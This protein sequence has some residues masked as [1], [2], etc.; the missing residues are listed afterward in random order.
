MSLRSKIILVLAV[1]AVAWAVGD[2]LLLETMVT[3][4]F[5]AMG[6]EEV[7]QGLELV[8]SCID[9]EVELL[10]EKARFVAS[11]ETTRRFVTESDA[12]LV[13]SYLG[14]RSL[15]VVGAH[16]M[17]VCDRDGNVR[18][19]RIE[20]PE[21]RE[22][23]S[24]KTSFPSESL[25]PTHP[26]LARDKEVELSYLTTER[27]IMLVTAEPVTRP[28]EETRSGTV[29]MGRFLDEELKAGI[30]ARTS[31]PFEIWDIHDASLDERERKLVDRFTSDTGE[32]LIDED[33]DKNLFAYKTLEGVAGRPD[34][35]LR[36]K[37]EH[38]ILAQGAKI[39]D[40]LLLST[41]GTSILIFLV[42]LRVL[43]RTVINPLTRFTRF[44]I[45]VAE[46]DD[47]SA[48]MQ[49]DRPDEV[50]ILSREF[51]RMLEEIE[52]SRSLLVQTARQAG[53]SEIATGVLHNVGNVL[54]SV[55]VSATL[56]NRQVG[57]LAVSDLSKF[58][59]VL[60]ENEENLA[61]FIA[62]DPRGKH[63]LPFLRELQDTL[64]GQHTTLRKEATTLCEGIDHIA[65]LVRSQ[66]TYAGAR[67]VFEKTS[68]PEEIDA[69]IQIC[70]QAFGQDDEVEILREYQP[71]LPPVP[72]DKH[73]LM[74]ILVNLIQNAKQAVDDS[75]HPRKQIILRVVQTTQGALRIEVEDNGAGIAP[76]NLDKIFN[77]GFTTKKGGHG[78]GLHVS[79][80]SAKEMHSSLNVRSDGPGQGAVFT[81]EIPMTSEMPLQAA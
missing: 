61:A 40:F 76:F 80:N 75:D 58:V 24:L 63:T 18:W 20:D 60:D 59:A 79:A 11:M 55:N 12:D 23:I 16:L 51:D 65:E 7:Q 57:Q 35:L 78:F 26:L 27:G 6:E 46:T 52:R 45:Q 48:R 81:L 56:L 69:A 47:T 53:M 21:T 34:V 62:E 70:R 15:A 41:I 36:A 28:D 14:P 5:R 9:D 43:Q 3:S 42:L 17:Y 19:G 29:I 37:K 77:H 30:E 1:V 74:E 72:V 66:Q 67:G 10:R 13:R 2:R 22:K 44:A 4:Q 50:G 31:L 73:K 64:D 33:D 39:T 25:A 71:D 32:V 68:L 38:G 8:E 49:M 54:N